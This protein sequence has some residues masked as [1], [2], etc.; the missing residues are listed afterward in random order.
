[1]RG[2]KSSVASR[3]C[4]ILLIG[5]ANVVFSVVSTGECRRSGLVVSNG[6]SKVEDEGGFLIEAGA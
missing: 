1:V 4:K 3:A 6:G 2:A 5:L